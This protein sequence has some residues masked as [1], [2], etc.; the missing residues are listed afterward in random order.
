MISDLPIPR[1]ANKRFRWDKLPESRGRVTIYEHPKPDHIYVLGFDAG[2]GI[3]GR[4]RT[5]LVVFD[6]FPRP[7]KQVAMAVGQWGSPQLARLCYGLGMFF[8]TAFVIGE[9]QVGL[10]ALQILF[11]ELHYPFLYYARDE[12][13]KHRPVSEKLGYWSGEKTND[14]AFQAL[15][16]AVIEK[17]ADLCDAEL[18]EEMA[19]LQWWNSREKDG[20]ELVG[21]AHLKVRLP[22]GADAKRR[23]PDLVMAC[24]M[25]WWGCMEVPHYEL[26]PDPKKYLTAK[27]Y[28]EEKEVFDPRPPEANFARMGD[29]W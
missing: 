23:S 12:N 19:S 25:A 27:Q 22:V 24:A 26:P 5:P 7:R 2:Y 8:N 18:V 1:L 9:A 11:H 10:A 15:R 20:V 16:R 4:D 17:E 28:G 3:E 13:K 29:G 6:T 21:D 14:Q